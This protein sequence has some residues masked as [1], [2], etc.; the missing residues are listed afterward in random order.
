[1]DG[2]LG[3]SKEKIEVTGSTDKLVKA[4][5]AEFQKKDYLSAISIYKKLYNKSTNQKVKAASLSSLARAQ[6]K[7]KN[8]KAA[9]DVY[10]KLKNEFKMLDRA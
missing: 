1:M 8:S 7:L 9:L 5:I 2:S 4:Q 6:K 10:T 3:L